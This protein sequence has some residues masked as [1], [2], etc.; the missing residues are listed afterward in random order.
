MST[1]ISQN[2]DTEGVVGNLGSAGYTQ[3]RA[4]IK[5]TESP[6]KASDGTSK[7]GSLGSYKAARDLDTTSWGEGTNPMGFEDQQPGGLVTD[8]TSPEYW[9]GTVVQTLDTLDGGGSPIQQANPPYRA[10]SNPPAAS[11]RDT[12]YPGPAP[13][14][15]PLVGGGEPVYSS[16]D[17]NPYGDETQ[18]WISGN[19]DTVNPRYPMQT[20]GTGIPAA[21]DTPTATG[22]N[23]GATVTWA[24]VANPANAHIRGYRIEAVHLSDDYDGAGPD[25][26]AVTGTH[27]QTSAAGV[28]FAGAD[29]TSVL[30]SDVVPGDRYAFRVAA[31]NDNGTG[32][33]SPWSNVVV[34]LDAE[35]NGPGRPTG[36]TAANAVN[37]VYRPD[38]TIV[39][40]TGGF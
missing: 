39:A 13:S 1:D 15:N 18:D 30:F 21:P 2:Y 23:S 25:T 7:D 12:T 29:A 10:P 24:S 20:T 33:Y 37:P 8:H 19:F 28:V 27:T 14:T 16:G 26:A 3:D 34:P 32:P 6:G 9:Q 36:I 22:V 35:E 40:G 4:S 31:V 17:T 11:D 38:G 5:D